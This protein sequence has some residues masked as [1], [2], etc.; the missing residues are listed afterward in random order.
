MKVCK[1]CK[2]EYEGEHLNFCD[3]CFK[4][5]RRKSYNEYH[6]RVKVGSVDDVPFV[7]SECWSR[8]ILE[9]VDKCDV[10]QKGWYY[11]GHRKIPGY[12]FLITCKTCTVVDHC[13]NSNGHGEDLPAVMEV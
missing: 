4:E 1:G 9:I 6:H 11:E 2:G 8:L 10:P 3:P 5:R 13:A 7:S 12:K